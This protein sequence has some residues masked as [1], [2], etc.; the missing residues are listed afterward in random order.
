MATDRIEDLRRQL[1]RIKKTKIIVGVQGQ[2]AARVHPLGRQ[3]QTV[4][5]VAIANHYG[6]TNVPARPFLTIAKQRHAAQIKRVFAAAVKSGRE[7]QVVGE[8]VGAY[9]VGLVQETISDRIPP[10]N[11]PSTIEKKQSDTPLIDTGILRQSI[12]F[13]VEVDA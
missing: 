6:T 8:L 1:L 11:A 3:G 2:N 7:P 13:V 9:V 10:P 4:G 12:D 5:E